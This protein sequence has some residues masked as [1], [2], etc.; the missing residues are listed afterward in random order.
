M[1]WRKLAGEGAQTLGGMIW[2]SHIQDWED[3]GVERMGE[4]GL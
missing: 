4:E 2:N 1:G 3:M